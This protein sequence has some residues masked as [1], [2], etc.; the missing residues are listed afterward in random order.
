MN[1]Q[2]FDAKQSWELLLQFLGE[3]W[4][5]KNSENKIPPSE[6]EAATALLRRIG[7]V[8]LAIQQAANLIKDPGVGGP[9][10][11]QTFEVFKKRYRDFKR[12]NPNAESDTL[13]TINTLWDMSWSRLDTK[14][15][16]LLGVMAWMSPGKISRPKRQ[17]I[18]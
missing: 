18:A 11:A 7:G 3:D 8:S 12:R 10:I 2:P 17:S 6:I 15:K 14:S 13:R 4:K 5:Q 16:S 9:T 1:V